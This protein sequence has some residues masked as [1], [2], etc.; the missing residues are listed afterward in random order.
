MTP[1]TNIDAEVSSQELSIAKI[2]TDIFLILQEKLHF[3]I[4]NCKSHYFFRILQL[5]LR[6]TFFFKKIEKEKGL[7]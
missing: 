5:F 7:E 4:S 1:S 6:I 3:Y 2:I